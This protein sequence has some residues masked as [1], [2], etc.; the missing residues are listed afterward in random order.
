MPLPLCLFSAESRRFLDV[1]NIWIWFRLILSLSFLLE[2][3]GCHVL[4]AFF[5]SP[6]CPSFPLDHIESII[7]MGDLRY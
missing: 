3:L 2:G 7:A 5:V 1:Q 6:C 4:A